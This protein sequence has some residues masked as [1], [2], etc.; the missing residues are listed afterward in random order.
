MTEQEYRALIA[1]HR[2]HGMAAV[3]TML[4]KWRR[5]L[6][7]DPKTDPIAREDRNQRARLQLRRQIAS[8][9]YWGA[10]VQRPIYGGIC[11]A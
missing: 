8:Q 9:A 5:D 6:W 7:P 11:G 1:R 3:T 10:A 2:F 4:M